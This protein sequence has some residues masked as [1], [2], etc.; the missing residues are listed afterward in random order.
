MR[1]ASVFSFRT[2]R[3]ER[4]RQTD[5]ARVERLLVLADEIAAEVTAERNGLRNR[6]QKEVDDAGFLLEANSNGDMA[7]NEE[8][9][10]TSLSSSVISAESRLALLDKQ[11]AWLNKLRQA[12]EKFPVDS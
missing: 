6:R 9:R 10:L 12:M 4:D 1:L 3:P 7:A 11:L 2:R 8:S 5:H